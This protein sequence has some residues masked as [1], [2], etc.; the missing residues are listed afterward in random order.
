MTKQVT[1][2]LLRRHAG[3]HSGQ[4]GRKGSRGGSQG[5]FSHT[6]GGGGGGVSAK[7]TSKEARLARAAGFNK[8]R[9]KGASPLWLKWEPDK[10]FPKNRA[11][12]TKLGDEEFVSEIRAHSLFNDATAFAENKF[13]DI[14]SAIDWANEHL[15]D[16]KEEDMPERS[17]IWDMD[18]DGMHRSDLSTGRF[19][20]VL[21]DG[22]LEFGENDEELGIVHF[23]SQ[24]AAKEAGGKWMDERFNPTWR[25]YEERS[26]NRAGVVGMLRRKVGQRTLASL[27]G[28]TEPAPSEEEPDKDNLR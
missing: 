28:P 17:V 9:R 4:K 16:R 2:G 21:L 15:S 12:I 5:G 11:R 1:K 13:S 24:E 27:L 18:E 10:G 14:D 23:D 7:A 19:A 3:G 22:T 8:I 6:G 26:A 20:H 25:S